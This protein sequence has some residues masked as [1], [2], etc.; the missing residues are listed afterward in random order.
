MV[1][2]P[3]K[4]KNKEG[5]LTMDML[6]TGICISVLKKDGSKILLTL[7]GVQK[8]SDIEVIKDKIYRISQDLTRSQNP[9]VSISLGSTGNKTVSLSD[10]TWDHLQ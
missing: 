9:H 3:A 2:S 5:I 10:L 8:G 6:E 1:I 7:Y 4:L